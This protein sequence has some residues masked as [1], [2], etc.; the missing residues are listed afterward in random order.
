MF[1]DDVRDSGVVF[2]GRA[3]AEQLDQLV[4][5]RLQTDVKLCVIIIIIVNVVV[6]IIRG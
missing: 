4:Q 1:D 2:A 5:V 3:A 6:I